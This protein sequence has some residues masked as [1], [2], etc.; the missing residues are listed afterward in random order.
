MPAGR[1]NAGLVQLQMKGL[2]K[3]KSGNYFCRKQL[4]D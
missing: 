3:H 1:V 4:L 2:V